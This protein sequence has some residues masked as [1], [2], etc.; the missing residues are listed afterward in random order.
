MTRVGVVGT[1]GWGKN[2]LRVLNELDCLSAFCD[3]DKSKVETY[4][5]KYRAPGYASLDEMIAK[6]RLDAVT[7]CTP[8][9]THHSIA[10]KT[11]SAGLHTFVEKPFATNTADAEKMIEEA[12]KADKMLTVGFIERFNPPISELRKMISKK[13]LGELLLLEFHRENKRGESITD[14]G[15]VRDASVHDIDTACWLF[16]SAP[17]VVFARVGRVQGA[18]EHE[19]FATIMLGFSGQKTAF[20]VTNWVTP[21]R[22]R[23]LSAVFAAG[24]VD[25]DFV[26][27]QTSIHEAGGT[28][29]PTRPVQEPLMLELKEFTSAV[30]EKRTPLVTGEDGLRATRV[31]E[32]ILA[33]SSSGTPIYLG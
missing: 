28:R 12:K 16:E 4:S 1:G 18:P 30:T 11:L 29:V 31:A 19:D 21:S 26:S 6:E 3:V 17:R 20:L 2:H 33:S 7:I 15:I 27:Q 8:A 5:K 23:T 25:V 9:S 32:A 14:V 22:V 13:E 24:V 10:S